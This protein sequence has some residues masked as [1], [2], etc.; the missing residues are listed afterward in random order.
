MKLVRKGRVTAIGRLRDQLAAKAGT[1][2]ACPLTTGI[3]AWMTAHAAEEEWEK[4]AQRVTP[5]WRTLKSGGELHPK[6]PGGPDRQR[7]M[8]EAEGHTV[9]LRG[10]RWFVEGPV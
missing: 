3:F 5:W 4:G 9:V 1:T 6:Y 8:L 2:I 10:E 7:E